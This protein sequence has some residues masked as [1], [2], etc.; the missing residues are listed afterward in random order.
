M[1]FLSKEVV[2]LFKE[3]FTLGVVLEVE[4]DGFLDLLVAEDAFVLDLVGFQE[5]VQE[6][7][8]DV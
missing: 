3:I 4:V 6:A 7:K 8:Y 2:Y 5:D 1:D